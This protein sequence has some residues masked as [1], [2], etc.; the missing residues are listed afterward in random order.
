LKFDDEKGELSIVKNGKV[1][2]QAS[3]TTAKRDAKAQKFELQ[4]TGT[5]KER[6]L[7]GIAFAGAEQNIVLNSPSASR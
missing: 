2:A 5:G 7:V 6:Q 1:L 3:T 4:L